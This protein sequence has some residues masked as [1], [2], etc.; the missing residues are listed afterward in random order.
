MTHLRHHRT[1]SFESPF[2]SQ[3]ARCPRRHGFDTEFEITGEPMVSAH[4]RFGDTGFGGVQPQASAQAH[5]TAQTQTTQQ[6]QEQ[7]SGGPLAAPSGDLDFE[8]VGGPTMP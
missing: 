7:E 1:L 3:G 8:S 6:D 5:T 2:G 4:P